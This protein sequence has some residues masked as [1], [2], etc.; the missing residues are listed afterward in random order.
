MP[1]YK[2][3]IAYDG[4][5][6]GG[7]QS[8]CNSVCIQDILEKELST[9]LRTPTKVHG[10]GRT[11]AGVHAMGQTAHFDSPAILNEQK[12]MYSL[13]CMLPQEVRIMALLLVDDHFHAR[14]SAKGKI[15]HYHLH[16]DRVADPF[17]RKY[18]LHV[19]HKVNLEALRQAA[20]LLVGKHD[21]RSFANE[22]HQ[23]SAS[24]DSVRALRRL[25][26]VEEMGG[27]RLEFEGDGFLYKMVRN[28]TG[29]L[30]EIASGKRSVENVLQILAAKDRRAAGKAAE[31]QGLFLIQVLY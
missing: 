2:I 17:K 27:V 6:F 8:Q 22:P 26:I 11:D 9:L 23:G 20:F 19:R 25:Q 30:L 3:T 12:I 16:L 13:N 7:W 10:S 21:F 28:I 29:T 15:Y 1:R 14:F 24:R 5:L 31:P 18:S 4:S